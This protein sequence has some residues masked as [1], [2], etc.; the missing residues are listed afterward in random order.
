MLSSV[1]G[2]NVFP[3]ELF[4][5][6]LKRGAGVDRTETM[7]HVDHPTGMEI[8]AVVYLFVFCLFCFS[9]AASAAYGG[10]QARG[11][12]GAVVTGLH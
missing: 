11:P 1:H 6:R 5:A 12:I 3:K 4:G 2:R 10:S 8:P 7:S 9:R